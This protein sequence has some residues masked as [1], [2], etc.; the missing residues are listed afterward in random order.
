MPEANACSLPP[1][2]AHMHRRADACHPPHQCTY[3]ASCFQIV[4]SLPTSCNDALDRY[5]TRTLNPQHA[6]PTH[7]H[8]HM[9]AAANALLI[10]VGR[11]SQA[12]ENACVACL[13]SPPRRQENSLGPILPMVQPVLYVQTLLWPV[14]NQ[15]VNG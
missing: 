2:G 12:R 10:R 11:N 6:W 15:L 14:V 13:S 8:R 9:D 4:E 1:A 5:D 7:A 3:P